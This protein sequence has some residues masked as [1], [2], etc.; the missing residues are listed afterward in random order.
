MKGKTSEPSSLP[1]P[2]TCYVW[3]PFSC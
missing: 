3:N 2:Q 1:P